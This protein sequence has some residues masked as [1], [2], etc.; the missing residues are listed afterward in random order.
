MDTI[1]GYLLVGLASS[2]GREPSLLSAVLGP[3][4]NAHKILAVSLTYNQQQLFGPS[5]VGFAGVSMPY[6]PK[7]ELHCK[8]KICTVPI[9]VFFMGALH[10]TSGI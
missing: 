9:L 5:N 10:F 7:K 8:V 3:T 6:N 2:Q 4:V 1:F